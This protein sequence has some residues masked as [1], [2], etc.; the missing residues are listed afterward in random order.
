MKKDSDHSLEKA[1][2][3]RKAINQYKR[4]IWLVGIILSLLVLGYLFLAIFSFIQEHL[5]PRLFYGMIGDV[6]LFAVATM[7]LLISVARR[8]AFLN[9]QTYTKRFFSEAGFIYSKTSFSRRIKGKMKKKKFVGLF[10]T[11]WTE[12]INSTILTSYGSSA[13]KTIN[14]IYL[15]AIFEHCHG[16]KEY[17]YCFD[18]LDGFIIYKASDDVIDFQ[19]DLKEI[20]QDVDRRAKE[21][22]TLPMLRQLM[23]L[24]LSNYPDTVDE[25][26][27]RASFAQHYSGPTRLD[28]EISIYSPDMLIQ[29]EAE[30]NLAEEFTKALEQKQLEVYYQPQYDVKKKR[31]VGAEALVRWNHP[32]RGLL[33]PSLFIPF[34]ERTGRVIEVDRY[35]FRQVCLDIKKWEKEKRR[36]VRVSVNMSRKSTYDPN[37]LDYYRKTIKELNVNPLLIEMEIT[38]SAAARDPIFV[39]SIIKDLKDIGLSVAMDDFG[40]GYSS[41]GTLKQMPFNVLKID[42]VFIDDIEVDKKARI[43]VETIISIGHALDMTVIA[44]GVQSQKQSDILE[45]MDLDLIQ[46]FYY[47][48]VLPRFEFEKLIS[49]EETTL[50]KGGK[51]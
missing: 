51:K 11:I 33:P 43:L 3:R 1:E 39:Y 2:N 40:V 9:E 50:T 23:G 35:V 44:E 41:L 24:Y 20:S 45:K 28:D 12:N 22:G 49:N 14:D 38:E 7:V 16:H 19:N 42:K 10:G 21:T 31:F 6:V 32:S 8:Q 17:V 27:D 34:A 46:G 15:D 13:V 30:K 25:A 26:I 29:N 4:T 36:L 48:H 47:S 18:V 5:D 37:M